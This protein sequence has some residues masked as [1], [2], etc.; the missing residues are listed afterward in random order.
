MRGSEGHSSWRWRAS[1]RLVTPCDVS[2]LAD[3]LVELALLSCEDRHELGRHGCEIV[4]ERFNVQHQSQKLRTVF[5]GGNRL[6]QVKHWGA[7]YWAPQWDFS[8]VERE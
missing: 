6:P 3:A 2:G 5:G 1:R 7:L 4:V 8:P